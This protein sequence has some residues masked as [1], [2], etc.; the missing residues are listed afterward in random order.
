MV[1]ALLV[2]RASWQ[3]A[4]LSEAWDEL[5][6]AVPRNGLPLRLAPL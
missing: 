3:V 4:D 5:P 6:L 1:L 2:R